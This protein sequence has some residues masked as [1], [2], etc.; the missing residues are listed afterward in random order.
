MVLLLSGCV[1]DG[2]VQ[3]ISETDASAPS[4]DAE[5]GTASDAA[6]T[7]TDAASAADAADAAKPCVA[8]AMYF[9][10]ASADTM[11]LN[12]GNAN[13][14]I[15]FG[16]GPNANV[17]QVDTGHEPSVMLVRFDVT[18]VPAAAWSDPQTVAT[19]A[20][21]RW[22][23]GTNY[24]ASAAGTLQVYPM[25]SDWS[26]GD[27][28]AYNGAA[29]SNRTQTAVGNGVPWAGA[30]ATGADRGAMP[31]A[32]QALLAMAITPTA[33]PAISVPL[34]QNLSSAATWVAGNK[35]TLQLVATS[36]L[37]LYLNQR[38]VAAGA[39]AASLTINYCP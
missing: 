30:G 17:G 4:S 5:A 6:S 21:T 8:S 34:S 9:Q 37:L 10:R 29:W 19:L 12:N 11:L 7:P 1:G 32:S 2:A 13:P 25:S 33:P 36:G 24:L 18:G 39:V 38:E 16:I 35:L 27:N 26:E 28:T 23:D 3:S 14:A 20:I 22:S 31:I 15:R